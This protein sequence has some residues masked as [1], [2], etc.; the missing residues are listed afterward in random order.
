MFL[1]YALFIILPL[2]WFAAMFAGMKSTYAKE[3]SSK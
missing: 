3:D 1:F 2:L